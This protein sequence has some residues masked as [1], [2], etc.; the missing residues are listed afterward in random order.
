MGD[1]KE[2]FE[3]LARR[4]WLMEVGEVPIRTANRA[5][6]RSLLTMDHAVRCF[7]AAVQRLGDG[8]R[9]L[10]THGGER[11]LV[12]L[13]EAGDGEEWLVP[14]AALEHSFVPT[15]SASPWVKTGAADLPAPADAPEGWR[16]GDAHFDPEPP[17]PDILPRGP[18]MRGGTLA[19]RE[20]PSHFELVYGDDGRRKETSISYTDLYTG[21][22]LDGVSPYRV[23]PLARPPVPPPLS[24]LCRAD[25]R[26]EGHPVDTFAAMM[27][28]LDPRPAV[29]ARLLLPAEFPGGPELALAVAI[30]GMRAALWQGEVPLGAAWLAADGFA[31]TA[32]GWGEDR[33]AALAM[34]RRELQEACPV[35]RELALAGVTSLDSRR[36][37]ADRSPGPLRDGQGEVVGVNFG[38]FTFEADRPED[39]PPWP[40]I[41]PDNAPLVALPLGQ[42]PPAAPDAFASRG[43]EPV[44]LLGRYG[45]A[46]HGLL[47][48]D[49]RGWLLVG[50]GV[51][52]LVDLDQLEVQLDDAQS[53]SPWLHEAMEV[54]RYRYRSTTFSCWNATTG[55]PMAPAMKAAS[56]TNEWKPG[57]ID[58]DDAGWTVTH[59]V[60]AGA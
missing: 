5:V 11:R 18:S 27:A 52:D 53:E 38:T 26:A 54:Q 10:Q 16:H 30:K 33:G 15:S 58:G 42:G 48:H 28:E 39:L 20:G 22:V 59:V 13:R 21:H 34:L 40:E 36:P 7:D 12:Y 35:P 4:D 32:V 43:F 45:A 3:Q 8:A 14:W 19:M 51:A 29:P 6:R 9:V 46:R 41:R 1:P 44:T 23:D 57:F 24:L 60:D 50:A 55:S 37:A 56:T 2:I 31:G 17:L 49:Q 25:L 47:R